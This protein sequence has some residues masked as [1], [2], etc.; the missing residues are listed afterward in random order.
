MKTTKHG[1]AINRIARPC[2]VVFLLTTHTMRDRIKIKKGNL[3]KGSDVVERV[4]RH[5]QRSTNRGWN[6]TEGFL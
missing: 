2:F 5:Y 3:W 6:D 4:Q 1:L